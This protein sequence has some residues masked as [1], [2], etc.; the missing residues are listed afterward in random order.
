MVIVGNG[1]GCEE[2]GMAVGREG[3]CREK[4]LLQ[5]KLLEASSVKNK[6]Q[7]RWEGRREN[8]IRQCRRQYG[9]YC[10]KERKNENERENGL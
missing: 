4:V 5:E 10:M 8:A 1:S 9:N 7:A 3:S 6:M 2:G